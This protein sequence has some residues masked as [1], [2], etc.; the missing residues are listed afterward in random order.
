MPS[1]TDRNELIAA[2]QFDDDEES[3][4]SDH[5]VE[6]PTAASDESVP[7]SPNGFTVWEYKAVLGGS[8]SKE[9]TARLND[10]GVDGWELV[11]VEPPQTGGQTVLYLKRPT[12]P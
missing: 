6:E 7:E 3:T 2:L 10:L 4:E 11:G 8:G 1:S 9:A 12:R 5:A